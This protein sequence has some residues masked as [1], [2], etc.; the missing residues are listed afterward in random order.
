MTILKDAA[1]SSL[2]GSRAANGVV[3]ITT[4]RGK[5]GK[6]V[7]NL[8][9]AWGT[10]DAAVPFHTK[11]DPKQQLL[12]NWRALYNDRVYYHGADPQ[13]AGDYASA[14]AVGLSVNPSTNSN[15]ETWYVTPFKWPGSASNF[16]LHDGNGNPTLN[17]DL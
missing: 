9:A 16:V 8:R 5:S 1:A 17:P 7:V 12:N 3:V 6:P 11:A 4:K 14:N 15:G 13:T 2:Y 10:S